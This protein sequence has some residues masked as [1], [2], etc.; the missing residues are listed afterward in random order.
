MVESRDG[1]PD[2]AVVEVTAKMGLAKRN[3]D[4][5]AEKDKTANSTWHFVWRNSNLTLIRRFRCNSSER[6]EAQGFADC[7]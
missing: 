2:P 6:Q 7:W 4:K 1:L 5:A 3:F